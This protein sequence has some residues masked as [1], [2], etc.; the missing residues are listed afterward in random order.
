LL[1]YSA[2][3]IGRLRVFIDADGNMVKTKKI[4][5]K[6]GGGIITTRLIEVVELKELY[7][8]KELKAVGVS[9]ALLRREGYSFKQM[10]S[11]GE[12]AFVFA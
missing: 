11:A 7:S 6:E 4:V 2:A 5:N 10:A 8:L 3:D 9:A 1:G 12:K